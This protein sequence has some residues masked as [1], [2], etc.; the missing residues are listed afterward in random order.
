MDMKRLKF[1]ELLSWYKR[2]IHKPLIIWGARQVGKSYL[3]EELFFK[4]Y[5]KDYIYIDLK[6]DNDSNDF[7]SK[8][9]DPKKCIRYIE[10][11]FGKKITPEVPIAFD[12]VQS[13][14][15]VLTTLKYFYQDYPNLTIIASGSMVRL[16][17]E[18]KDKD[19]LFPVGKVENLYLYPLTFE[20][21]LINKNPIINDHIKEAYVNRV[22]LPS[23]E[24][25]IALNLLYEY[26]SIGGMPEVVD[27]YLKTE[28]YG[29]A[30]RLRKNVYDNYLAD[31]AT[32]NVSYETILKTQ[33]VYQ[34]IFTQLNKE[35]KNFKVT[36]IDKKKSNRDYFN[37]YKWLEFSKVVYR[38]NKLEGKITLPFI[39]KSNGLFRM[40]LADP[41]I[42]TLQS[43]IDNSNFF[44]KD[45]QNTLAGI[46]YENYVACELM[47]YDIPLYY[48]CGKNDFEMEFIVENN[49]YAVPIDVKKSNGKMN[50]L[51]NFRE[52]NKR[53]VAVK[54][55]TNNFGYDKDNMILTIPLYAVYL[56]AKDIKTNKSLV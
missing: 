45:K 31:M 10:S 18:E 35:N 32:Y 47:S 23:Y 46:F 2:K 21:Y 48:W 52:H 34:N 54:I 42:F 13:C 28:S 36:M 8:N 17:L 3:I 6:K 29:E 49:G 22:P 9:N 14:V 53:Y 20:E 12:E 19:F 24:H 11:K 7:F 56:L 5:F 43:N 37:A 50:S 4:K 51:V 16:A 38:S 44:V 26:L 27:A 1:E 41:G 25:D 15:N 39:S 33:A 30:S 55:S 40:Y